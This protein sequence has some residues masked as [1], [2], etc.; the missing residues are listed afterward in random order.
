VAQSFRKG[1]ACGGGF[2]EGGTSGFGQD[3]SGVG[4]MKVKELIAALK[5][6]PA[7]APVVFQR[8]NDETP[9]YVGEVGLMSLGGHSRMDDAKDG[10]FVEIA[11]IKKHKAVILKSLF[12]DELTEPSIV[13]W[14]DVDERMLYDPKGYVR[15]RKEL[16]R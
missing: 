3:A 1:K 12:W 13:R 15:L 4:E 16:E 9:N 11:K 6:C 14:I 2:D 7:D 10:G 8:D 5:K